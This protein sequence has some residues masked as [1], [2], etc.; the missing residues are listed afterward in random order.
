MN[1]I[2]FVGAELWYGQHCYDVYNERVYIHVVYSAFVLYA[3]CAYVLTTLRSTYT[4]F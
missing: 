4:C 2:T 1:D 3:L